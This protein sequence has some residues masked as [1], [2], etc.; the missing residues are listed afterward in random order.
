MYRKAFMVLI[1]VNLREFG[2]DANL[3]VLTAVLFAV[4]CVVMHLI[5]QPYTD[6]WHNII[7]GVGL[8]AVFSTFF[9]I[10][11]YENVAA[12]SE[13]WQSIV[14]GLAALILNGVFIILR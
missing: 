3:Q 7:E 13:G 8:I 1:A 10:L 2:E 5:F 6:R 11:Y 12:L 9:T 14:V 4:I